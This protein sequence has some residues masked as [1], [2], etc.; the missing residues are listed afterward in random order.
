MMMAS[1][2]IVLDHEP[3]F[4][5]SVKVKVIGPMVTGLPIAGL[6]TL[7]PPR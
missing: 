7:Y 2:G 3:R 4:F 5:V 6:S 1:I